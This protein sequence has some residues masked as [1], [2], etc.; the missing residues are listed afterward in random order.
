MLKAIDSAL[1]AL[2]KINTTTM[3]EYMP[4]ACCSVVYKII[5]KLL[6]NIHDN[7]LLAHE[8]V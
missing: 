6:D 2:V 7:I 4:L 5:V 1:I 3:Q 8:S